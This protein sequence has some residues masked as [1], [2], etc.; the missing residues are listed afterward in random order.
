MRISLP[1]QAGKFDLQWIGILAIVASKLLLSTGYRWRAPILPIFPAV[2]AD[3]KN[4]AAV[5][6]PFGYFPG[7]TVIEQGRVRRGDDEYGNLFPAI[8]CAP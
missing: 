1:W 6:K 5:V 3:T 2:R 7:I 8:G 4:N